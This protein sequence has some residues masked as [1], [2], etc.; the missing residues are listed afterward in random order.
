MSCTQ[1]R[2]DQGLLKELEGRLRVLSRGLWKDE[3]MRAK[4]VG[5]FKRA[6][7]QKERWDD[8]NHTI[9][10]KAIRAPPRLIWG[11]KAKPKRCRNNASTRYVNEA[12]ER[13]TIS[14]EVRVRRE[15]YESRR[16]SQ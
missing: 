4:S 15:T 7:G 3:T 6:E 1:G 8:K 11:E 12:G 2:K 10:K 16:R 5:C 9:K 14:L 13:G